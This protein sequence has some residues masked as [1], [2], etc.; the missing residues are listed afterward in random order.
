MDL[1]RPQLFWVWF[2]FIKK[3]LT[4]FICSLHLSQNTF[5][6]KLEKSESFQL[7]Q[8]IRWRAQV[9]KCKLKIQ[10]LFFQST[11][12]WKFHWLWFSYLKFWLKNRIPLVFTVFQPPCHPCHPSST[13]SQPRKNWKKAPRPGRHG[14]V[15]C[16]KNNTIF[17][18]K[19]RKTHG[20]RFFVDQKLG[21][22]HLAT[23]FIINFVVDQ[24]K[25]RIINWR[26][27]NK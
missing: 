9:R 6:S 13:L 23:Y 16:E 12:T 20:L 24:T 21:K 2:S 1:P 18:G 14:L 22:L 8:N 27:C 11:K 15:S 3:A 17:S 7:G 26:R 25:F 10:S 19:K 4:A 5:S